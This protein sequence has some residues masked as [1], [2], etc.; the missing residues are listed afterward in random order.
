MI[1]LGEEIQR[2]LNVKDKYGNFNY[3]VS[4]YEKYSD[5]NNYDV[6]FEVDGNVLTIEL[7]RIKEHRT[8]QYQVVGNK[9]VY[10]QKFVLDD[11]YHNGD[12]IRFIHLGGKYIGKYYTTIKK[13]I[14]YM[15][16][17]NI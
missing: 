9:I 8:I 16:S 7:I 1:Y 3:I 5:E 14:E 12:E 13:H 2:L 17:R 4:L 15:I 6:S 11:S 10:D